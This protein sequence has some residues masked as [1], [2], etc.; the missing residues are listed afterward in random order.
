MRRNGTVTTPGCIDHNNRN[1]Q[2]VWIEGI[3]QLSTCLVKMGNERMV[4]IVKQY[5]SDRI[6]VDS[7]AD[8]GVSDPLAV[9]KTAQLMLRRGIT[10][11]DVKATCYGNALLA[12]GASGQ[13]SEKDWSPEQ[14][15]CEQSDLFAGNSVLRTKLNYLIKKAF[16]L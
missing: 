6:I 13:I 3:G 12:Y 5:G 7:S 10:E 8:W 14:Q 2:F 1:V 16:G 11:A 15:R 9:P 4:E